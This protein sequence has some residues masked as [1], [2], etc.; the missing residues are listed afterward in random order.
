ME[1]SRVN[2][3]VKHAVL[4]LIQLCKDTI[5]SYDSVKARW[6]LYLSIAILTSV[7]TGVSEYKDF[8]EISN[9]DGFKIVLLS[10]IQGLIAWRAFIDQSISRMPAETKKG[11]T[12]PSGG[13]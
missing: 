2:I 8:N 11:E 10:I 9:I 1:E 5:N 6:L 4:L 12:P 13:V 3:L 7:Y